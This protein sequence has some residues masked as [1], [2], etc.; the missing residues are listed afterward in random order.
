MSLTTGKEAMLM[1][2]GREIFDALMVQLTRQ[3]LV[4]A[5]VTIPV[6]S[7]WDRSRL[8]S[9]RDRIL[10]VERDGTSLTPRR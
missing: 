4:D 9:S 8:L 7:T 5:P 1:P 2:I 10:L 6:P 3:L